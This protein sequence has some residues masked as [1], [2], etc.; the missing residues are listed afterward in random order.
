MASYT[1]CV[2]SM[3]QECY[4]KVASFFE[5]PEGASPLPASCRSRLARRKVVGGDP[6]TEG[7]ATAKVRTDEQEPHK[8]ATVGG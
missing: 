4:R 8:E 5:Y 1:L 7:S 3:G 6:C 2:P